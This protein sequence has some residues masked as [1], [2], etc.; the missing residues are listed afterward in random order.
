MRTIFRAAI[1][2]LL[3]A[4]FPSLAQNTARAIFM[5]DLQAYVNQLPNGVQ[6]LGYEAKSTVERMG[7]KSKDIIVAVNRRPVRTIEEFR[8]VMFNNPVPIS[9]VEVIREG[10]PVSITVPQLPPGASYP[11]SGYGDLVSPWINSANS[12]GQFGPRTVIAE[13]GAQV[14][15]GNNGMRIRQ[16]YGDS[17]LPSLGV[18]QGDIITAINNR[19]LRSAAEFEATVFRS[20][21]VTSTLHVMRPSSGNQT[22][23]VSIRRALAPVQ[24]NANVVDNNV[25]VTINPWVAWANGFNQTAP[26]IGQEISVQELGV[27]AVVESDGLRISQVEN[28]GLARELGLQRGDLL[29]TFNGARVLSQGQ[30]RQAVFGNSN[31]NVEV[32]G[33]RRNRRFAC[34][35][36]R[37]ADRLV[38]TQRVRD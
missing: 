5:K 32:I 37:E 9:T 7:L 14:Q 1:M 19:P 2:A 31:A 24:T 35:I 4:T 29:M 21:A 30:F 3:V 11:D 28:R 26:T 6:L 36:R 22:F 17:I 38:A 20:G 18:Q 25:G 27:N 16:I 10:R 34:V 13:L 23:A 12:I 33:M 15:F 8:N